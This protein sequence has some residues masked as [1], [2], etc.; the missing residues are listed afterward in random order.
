METMKKVKASMAGRAAELAKI[1]QNGVKIIGVTPGG[2][3]PEEL[4][5]AVGAVPVGLIRGGDPESVALSA[6]YMPRFMDTFCRA[7]IAYKVSGDPLY[8]MVDLLVTALTDHNIRCIG[9]SFEFFTDTK[10]IRI[11][12]PH[13]KDERG[14]NFYLDDLGIL[15]KKLEEFTGNKVDDKKLREAIGRAN[16]IRG[17]LRKIS[18]LRKT[19]PPP[20][21]GRDFAILNHAT[22][23][24]DPSVMI[25]LLEQ[26][27]EEATQ[28]KEASTLKGPRIMLIASTLAEGDYKIWDLMEGAGSPIVIE[29]CHEGIRH[30][31]E[32]DEVILNGDIIKALA[33][34]CFMRRI[35]SPM[36]WTRGKERIDFLLKQARDFDVAG[37]VWYQL[38]YR[39][40]YEVESQYFDKIVAKELNIPML[41]IESDY[42]TSERGP[43]R[44]RVEAFIEAIEQRR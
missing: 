26:V 30:Y 33:D 39:D 10:V 7:Q 28:G 12:I 16:K 32:W 6:A 36:I 20:I 14:Y 31:W 17:L 3:T 23:R 18:L 27:Y 35:T 38:M 11:G 43:F 2:Y 24:V 42:D 25:E 5:Y 37:V 21:S 44:T 9:D 15:T 13:N 8:Q 40:E 4:I 19:D 41:K 22:H 1:K 29:D 34:R